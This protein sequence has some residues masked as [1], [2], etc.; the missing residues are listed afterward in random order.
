MSKLVSAVSNL[1][2]LMSAEGALTLIAMGWAV[3]AIVVYNSVAGELSGRPLH[4][5]TGFVIGTAVLALVAAG[6]FM[7]LIFDRAGKK[8]AERARLPLRRTRRV[9]PPAS[10]AVAETPRPPQLPPAGLP[11]LPP[12]CV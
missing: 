5:F 9:S 10:P 2:K 7:L 11:P 4:L 6:F 8:S 12:L 1:D 3:F